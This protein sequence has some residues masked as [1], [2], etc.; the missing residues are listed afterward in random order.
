MSS[1]YTISLLF[2]VSSTI[3]IQGAGNEQTSVPPTPSTHSQEL[4]NAANA[5]NDDLR[6]MEQQLATMRMEI[7]KATAAPAPQTPVSSTASATGN[8]PPVKP[9]QLP[10]SPELSSEPLIVRVISPAAPP[11]ALASAQ[12]PVPDQHRKEYSAA[13]TAA[14]VA[15]SNATTCAA[16]SKATD[17]LTIPSAAG[18]APAAC[19]QPTVATIV[20]AQAS[21]PSAHSSAPLADATSPLSGSDC[22]S[23][24]ATSP[25]QAKA[26][27]KPPSVAAAL[28]SWGSPDSTSRTTT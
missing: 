1:V 10:T 24:A 4:L 17:R 6:K 23:P 22:A 12:P 26:T 25:E 19:A 13:T 7:A 9:L 18:A 15:A 27:V 2:V 5:R 11:V 8:V 28:F 20:R 14:N 3:G 16:A 21:Q